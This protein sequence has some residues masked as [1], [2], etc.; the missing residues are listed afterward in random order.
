MMQQLKTLKNMFLGFPPNFDITDPK[1]RKEVFEETWSGSLFTG[2]LSLLQY[3]L[4]VLVQQ[5]CNV[6]S[7]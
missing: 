4:K 2:G 5:T 3:G 1:A 6:N 7:N